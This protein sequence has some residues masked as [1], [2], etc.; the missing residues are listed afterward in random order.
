MRGTDAMQESLFMIG[1][2][3]RRYCSGSNVTVLFYSRGGGYE[4]SDCGSSI[5]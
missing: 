1:Q 4:D 3:S 2:D 5:R